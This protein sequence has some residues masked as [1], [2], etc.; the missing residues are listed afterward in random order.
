MNWR[1][2]DLIP[3]AGEMIKP[4]EAIDIVGVEDL[5]LH[6]RRLWNALIAN[7]FGAELKEDGR[8]F[9]IALS[10]LRCNHNGNDRIDETVE[11]L[12]R[13]IARLRQPNGS[14]TR[15]Q[16]LGG[17]NMGDPT[18][19]RGELTYSFDRRFTEALRD[20]T[21]FGKLEIQVMAAF[22]SKYALALYEHMTRRVN[23]RNRWL[24]EYTVDQFR[25]VL[26]VG[27][28]QLVAFGNFKQR[29]IVPALTEV[30]SWAPFSIQIAYKKTGQRVTGVVVH[31][32]QKGR[33]ERARVRAELEKSKH[34]RKA[35]M[36]GVTETVGVVQSGTGDDVVSVLPSVRP[37]R[38]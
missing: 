28:K 25:E 32:L 1:T 30:N 2:L 37:E 11:R 15:F 21:L 23:L 27:P 33:D 10:E 22:S 3:V 38:L 7:A 34:G 17:N 5:T 16:L 12:M 29:A 19:P 18:R 4:A 26:G 36:R 20:S 31:W 24:E 6:D 8:D 13:T 35:R 14:V 9:R